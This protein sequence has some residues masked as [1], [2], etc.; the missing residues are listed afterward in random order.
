MAEN[1]E[2][3]NL[4]LDKTL[5][6]TTHKVEDFYAN[7]K[8]Q[9][10]MAIIA[11]VVII[12]GYVGY[13]KLI[14]EPMDIEAQKEIFMAQN[15][16]EMDSFALALN[17]NEKFKGFE[18]IAEEYGASKAGNLAHYYAGICNLRTGQYESAIEH[19]ED[20]STENLLIGPLAE[21]AIG[22]AYVELGDLDKGVNHYMK[23]ARM[24]KNKLTSP[25][26]LKKAGMVY[27]EKQ[28]YVDAL[29][30][31]QTIK[32]DFA[33]SQEAQD[34]DKYIARATALKEGN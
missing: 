29:E 17:G 32:K 24:T 30:A 26:F 2:T 27:E 15:Y 8:K 7:N 31:Y 6:D 28:S 9:I 22:D 10:N 11:V 12:G 33:E 34:I 23:A 21:G 16:F 18:A 5:V 20:F 25:V 4:D 19:L 3:N 14:V 13:K 1:K